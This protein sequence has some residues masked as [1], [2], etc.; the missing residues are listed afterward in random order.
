MFLGQCE[1]NHSR[2][3]LHLAEII[4]IEVRGAHRGYERVF[5]TRSKFKLCIFL[6]AHWRKL[7][8]RV[9]TY[10]D[11]PRVTKKAVNTATREGT[12]LPGVELFDPAEGAELNIGDLMITQGFALPLDD[13]Y[14]V[15]SRSS[16]PSNQS[17]STIEE[18]CVSS[19]TPLT[20]LTPHS[21][22]SMS[23]IND[24]EGVEDAHFADQLQHLQHKLNGNNSDLSSI[25]DPIKLTTDDLQNRNVQSSNTHGNVA[26]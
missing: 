18:L 15:R 26:R 25:V 9:V 10:K 1:V 2:G 21:P 5:Y 17:D 13:T 23:I 20:P 24:V 22:M 16:T 8:A 6:V 4:D 3:T 7:I 11:R 14:P 19:T 12:P